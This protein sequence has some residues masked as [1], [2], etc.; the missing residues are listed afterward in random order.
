MFSL[1][2][3][4]L[5]LLLSP[6]LFRVS[7]ANPIVLVKIDDPVVRHIDKIHSETGI[8][9][10]SADSNI[11]NEVLAMNDQ[12]RNIECSASDHEIL[13]AFNPEVTPT[14][15]VIASARDTSLCVGDS[16]LLF[17]MIDG[18][19]PFDISWSG[20]N[21]FSSKERNPIIP[22][23]SLINSGEY[24]VILIDAEGFADT[25]SIQIR[26]GE[27][28]KLVTIPMIDTVC[29]VDT[30][31]ISVEILGG[32]PEF[33]IQ[34]YDDLSSN[35]DPIDSLVSIFVTPNIGTTNFLVEVTDASGCTMTDT[36]TILF[37][38]IDADLNLID[39]V[40]CEEVDEV[41]LSVTNNDLEQM[42][43][44]QWNPAGAIITDPADGPVVDVDPVVADIFS[45]RLENQYGCLDTLTTNVTVSTTGE[46][47]TIIAEPDN[48]SPGRSST[49]TV[50]GCSDCTYIWS[51]NTDDTGL[52]VTVSP[53]ETTIYTV[54]VTDAK[55]CEYVLSAMVTVTLCSEDSFFVPDIF[56]PNGDG[57][58][59]NHCVHSPLSSLTDSI[60]LQLVIFDR[61]GEMVFESLS[62]DDCWDGTFNGAALAPDVYGYLLEVTCPEG[63]KIT[64]KGNVTVLR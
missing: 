48:I 36:S 34:W 18:A 12:H 1:V 55:G 46:D 3:F 8:L 9:K 25:S 30:R 41:T 62:F 43:T 59:D 5:L 27:V 58:N 52:V 42:L 24:I 16:L 56:T 37:V 11:R 31:S 54:I 33:Q 4:S 63:E 64:K 50:S 44:Y 35:N 20:P 19:A 51:P 39:P 60:K 14:A 53:P 40:I 47:L 15:E 2:A 28:F 26:V 38:P 22:N 13:T 49:I 32:I 45:V 29:A 6:T 21:D 7:Y 10:S 57:V 17:S 23:L 61:W